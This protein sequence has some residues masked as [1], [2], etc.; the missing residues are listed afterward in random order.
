[1]SKNHRGTDNESFTGFMP[2][3]PGH[4][5]CPVN[6]FEKYVAKLH[7]MCDRLWQH[8]VN[9]YL[10]DEDTWFSNRPMGK[11]TLA[12]FMKTL[13]KKCGLSK[14]YT[15]HSIRVTGAT[16][17]SQG[18]FSASQIMSVTG[19]KSV[20]SLAIYQ[21]VSDN[22]KL[23][24][25]QALSTAMGVTVASPSEARVSTASV[26]P[27]V[28]VPSRPT[29]VLNT[30]GENAVSATPSEIALI[31]RPTHTQSNVEMFT[32]PVQ[33]TSTGDVVTHS[34]NDYD[35]INQE[36]SG[37]D[38][39]SL[40]SSFDTCEGAVTHSHTQITKNYSP[41]QRVPLQLINCNIQSLNISITK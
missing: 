15:N 8:P 21:R 36:L 39:D 23:D 5:L 40:F 9:S 3:A 31:S 30:S 34:N 33:L 26:T 13:S 22:E 1:M 14:V 18:K 7:P 6:S 19:H 4:P 32:L 38:V 41:K 16:I 37:V 11:N 35:L 27:E 10:D 12:D 2:E 28:D 17:L 29:P 25:G 24:M 20:S